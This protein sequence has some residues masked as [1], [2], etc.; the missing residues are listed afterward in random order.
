MS[1]LTPGE[2]EGLATYARTGRLK[3]AAAEL[4]VAEQTLKNQLRAAYDKLGV[5]GAYPAF[6]AMGWLQLPPKGQE[7]D[8]RGRAAEVLLRID[9]LDVRLGKLRDAARDVLEWSNE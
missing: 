4:G 5:R 6:V 9:E 1:A 3:I 7:I 8:L 2:V